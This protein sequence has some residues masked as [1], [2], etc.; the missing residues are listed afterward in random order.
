[1][2]KE[3]SRLGELLGWLLLLAIA[4]SIGGLFAARRP[5]AVFAR[6]IFPSASEPQENFRVSPTQTDVESIPPIHIRIGKKRG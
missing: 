1:M 2:S 6:K 3:K 4:F 5:I